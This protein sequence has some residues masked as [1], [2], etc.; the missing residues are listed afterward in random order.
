VD[1]AQ[2]LSVLWRDEG[3]GECS[4]GCHCAHGV[5]DTETHRERERQTERERDMNPVL[6]KL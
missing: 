3:L 6:Q 1:E 4:A 2:S 5:A